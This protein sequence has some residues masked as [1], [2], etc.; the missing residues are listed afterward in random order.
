V[1]DDPI[2]PEF[3]APGSK[4]LKLCHEKTLSNFAF[5]FNLRR[6]TKDE[7]VEVGPGSCCSPRHPTYSYICPSYIS[8]LTIK[9]PQ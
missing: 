1:L 8:N 6:Y 9:I 7:V 5:N 2:K 4:R 3:K